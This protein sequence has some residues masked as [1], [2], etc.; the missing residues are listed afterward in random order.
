[1]FEDVVVDALQNEAHWPASVAGGHAPAFVD[2]PIAVWRGGEK[3]AAD[4]ELARHGPDSLFLSYAH[5]LLG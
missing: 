1:V 5:S 2:V 4:L 3:L